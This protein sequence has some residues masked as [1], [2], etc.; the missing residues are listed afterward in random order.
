MPYVRPPAPNNID[1]IAIDTVPARREVDLVMQQDGVV[2]I[3]SIE[4]IAPG[5]IFNIPALIRP[6]APITD[7]QTGFNRNL[8]GNATF[9]GCTFNIKQ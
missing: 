8:F 7:S 6:L 2:T 5:T 3:P 4:D 1:S 9:H